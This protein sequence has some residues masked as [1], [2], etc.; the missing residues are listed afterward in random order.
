[1]PAE[2]PDASAADKHRR[3]HHCAQNREVLLPHQMS[4]LYGRPMIDVVLPPDTR[5][6]GAVVRALPR[7]PYRP[8]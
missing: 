6:A 5:L 1:M 7:D 8:K 4:L 2:L 3:V